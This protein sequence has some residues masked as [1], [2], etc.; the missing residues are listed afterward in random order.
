M[1]TNGQAETSETGQ[2]FERCRSLRTGIGPNV[3]AKFAGCR[4]GQGRPKLSGESEGSAR[5]YASGL[6]VPAQLAS[7]DPTVSARQRTSLRWALLPADCPRGGRAPKVLPS[8][9]VQFHAGHG[10]WRAG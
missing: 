10:A 1:T 4:I 2:Q 3:R 5:P 6:R 7:H 8:L 9:E